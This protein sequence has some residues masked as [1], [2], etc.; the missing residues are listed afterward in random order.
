M[1]LANSDVVQG[2]LQFY[3]ELDDAVLDVK[4]D[5]AEQYLH[6][7][8]IIENHFKVNEYDKKNLFV[9]PGG[10]SRAGD[11]RKEWDQGNYQNAPALYFK[12]QILDQLIDVFRPLRNSN[13]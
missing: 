4:P 10:P 7:L 3:R 11:I 5:L 6:Q 1:W 13:L 2:C 12:A 8:I 9:L